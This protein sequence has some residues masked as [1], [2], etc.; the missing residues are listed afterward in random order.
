MLEVIFVLRTRC[1]A[2]GDVYVP[3]GPRALHGW[4]HRVVGHYKTVRGKVMKQLRN[5]WEELLVPT[6]KHE[7]PSR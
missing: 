3:I 4:I 6:F 2:E 7:K 1:S 5:C